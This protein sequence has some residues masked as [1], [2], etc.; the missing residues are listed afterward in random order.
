M[1]SI[2]EQKILISA[3]MDSHICLWDFPTHTLRKTLNG[4]KKGIY[5]LTEK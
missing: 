5:S 2:V 3:S 1:I 4:H